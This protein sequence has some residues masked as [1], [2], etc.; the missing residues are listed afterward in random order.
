MYG[1]LLES[2]FQ[3]LVKPGDKSSLAPGG[4]LAAD[5]SKGGN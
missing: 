4:G 2:R 1:P 3:S 5:E